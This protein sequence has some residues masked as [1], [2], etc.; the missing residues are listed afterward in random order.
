MTTN[1]SLYVYTLH[2]TVVMT[3]NPTLFL[4]VVLGYLVGDF[5]CC[6]Y[7]LD[8]KINPSSSVLPQQTSSSSSPTARFEVR[9]VRGLLRR[10]LLL[11]S[12]TI[13]HENP[14]KEV[15]FTA[16]MSCNSCTTAI[17]TLLSEIPGVVEVTTNLTTKQVMVLGEISMD[18]QMLTK[19]LMTWSISTGKAVTMIQ[20]HLSHHTS[21]TN[22]TLLFGSI[23][24]AEEQEDIYAIISPTPVRLM[25]W[26]LWL[27][28]RVAR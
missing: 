4:A 13:R 27:A 23:T 11:P 2:N 8:R 3:F 17:T 22:K 16:D 12:P 15:L 20:S 5:V 25:Q 21:S 24:T 26:A 1:I 19:A 28:P 14:M 18:E 6:D 10:L 7:K 9:W